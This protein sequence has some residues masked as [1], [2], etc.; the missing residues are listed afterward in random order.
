MNEQNN[1][2]T[3]G[4]YKLT[5]KREKNFVG[6][7]VAFKI[8]IDGEQVGKIKNGGVLE[9]EVTPGQHE[10]S[11]HK[12]NP[13]NIVIDRDTTADVVVFGANNFGITNINGQGQ[14]NPETQE[15]YLNRNSSNSN[16]VF[17]I[18]LIIPF[19]SIIML[20]TIKYVVAVWVYGIVIGYCIVNIVGL[21][22]LKTTDSEKYK[23]LLI[24]NIIAIVVNIIAIVLTMTVTI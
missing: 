22:N 13:T 8:Y 15:H 16:Y 24:K 2:T 17:Y 20:Y 7:L 19:V 5:L 1:I 9:L 12:K 10:I 6:C 4:K 18:S 14:N 23:S 11:V 21:K 3:P